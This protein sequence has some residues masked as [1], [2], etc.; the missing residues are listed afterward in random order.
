[1][2]QS[3]R[4]SLAVSPKPVQLR[5]SALYLAQLDTEVRTAQYGCQAA[6]LSRLI[7][8]RQRHFNQ[9][10]DGGNWMR[11]WLV[12]NVASRTWQTGQGQGQECSTC[13][14]CNLT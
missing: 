11:T 2:K 10:S 5:K 8:A 4:A 12:S 13:L 14:L 9:S 1:M 7:N 3:A 6:I